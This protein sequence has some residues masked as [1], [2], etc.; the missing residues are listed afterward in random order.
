MDAV[1]ASL[2]AHGMPSERVRIERFA[3]S[4]PKH[5]HVPRP[6]PQAARTECEV[7][8]VIDGSQRTFLLEKG[9]E[10][11]ID[12]G[13]RNGIELPF[14]CKGGVCSTCRCKLV[15]GEVDMDV[16]FALE[17]YEVARGFILACQS[18]PVTDKVTVD[19]DQGDR[20]SHKWG[21]CSRRFR[22]PIGA[23]R[24]RVIAA[25]RMKV[26]PVS[27]PFSSA[28]ARRS[29]APSKRSAIAATGRRL[30]SR[31]ARRSTARAPP[32]PARRNTMHCSIGA[33]R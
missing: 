29:I 13:L 24:A 28:I 33:F 14:S 20:L 1:R 32:K 22:P 12:A 19:F 11:I 9:R 2:I 27:N 15:A 26:P 6:L 31:R 23:S 3:A 18:Y 4:I 30:P 21:S 8:V 5:T 25:Q 7:S 10:N 16:N 17:D